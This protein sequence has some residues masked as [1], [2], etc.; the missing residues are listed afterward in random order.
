M[1][2][3]DSSMTVMGDA[4]A[5]V[6]MD[7]VATSAHGTNAAGSEET[8]NNSLDCAYGIETAKYEDVTGGVVIT[9]RTNPTSVTIADSVD[10]VRDDVESADP[11]GTEDSA[12][13]T[14]C[15][16]M[17]IDDIVDSTD[18]SAKDD[19]NGC[20]SDG[21]ST[22][23]TTCLEAMTPYG[24]DYYLRLGDTPRRRSALRLSRIIARKQLLQRLAKGRNRES[25]GKVI[26]CLSVYLE[27]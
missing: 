25:Y 11:V 26:M 27:S 2:A 24:K 17:E 7:S 22:N 9:E 10:N 1:E 3:V 19:S 21:D 16:S 5:A 18:Q 23:E 15:G 14:D 8:V 13:P 4:D 12:D 6:S 20:E